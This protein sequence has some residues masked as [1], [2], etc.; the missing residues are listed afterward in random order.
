MY[1][2]QKIEK[3]LFTLTTCYWRLKLIK[4]TFM[5][6]LPS[7]LLESSNYHVSYIP[8]LPLHLSGF[9]FH[10]KTNVPL[11]FLPSCLYRSS[12]K[13]WSFSDFFF[14]AIIFICRFSWSIFGKR[15]LFVAVYI[16]FLI[17]LD[18]G[19][20][21][22][23]SCGGK[24]SSENISFFT[25]NLITL[26]ISSTLLIPSATY[27]CIF[28]LLSV[29]QPVATFPHTEKKNIYIVAVIWDVGKHMTTIRKPH[30]LI[31]S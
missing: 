17:S 8:Y 16:W 19:K 10:Y 26:S 25:N 14:H 12:G 6:L 15:N 1:W 3:R 28:F 9:H 11:W 30:E 5:K 23:L 2:R 24:L 18:N 4:K 22:L 13:K 20:N 27:W 21:L 29:H 7:P 31:G